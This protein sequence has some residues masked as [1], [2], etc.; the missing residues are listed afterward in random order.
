MVEHPSA[1]GWP[2]LI[3]TSVSFGLHAKFPEYLEKKLIQGLHGRCGGS[4]WR[5]NWS[6]LVDSHMLCGWPHIRCPG[7]KSPAI[8]ILSP[9][10]RSSEDQK[11]QRSV[12]VRSRTLKPDCLGQP[13]ALGKV[14]DWISLCLT[15]FTC[16]MEMIIIPT[17]W[18]GYGDI[19]QILCL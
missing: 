3:G 19:I 1:A 18:G 4:F 17:W 8:A 12:V 16:K 14:S 10:W 2:S 15:F 6:S 5:G 7:G 11:R 13:G 9:S